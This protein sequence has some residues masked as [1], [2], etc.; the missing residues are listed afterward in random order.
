MQ[1]ES[2]MMGEGLNVRRRDGH[3]DIMS[4]QIRTIDLIISIEESGSA[5]NRKYPAIRKNPKIS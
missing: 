1:Q 3:K 4:I 2:A 5:T